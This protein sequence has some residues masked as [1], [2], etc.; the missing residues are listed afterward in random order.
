M[1]NFYM[2]QSG[3]RPALVLLP[4][5]PKCWSYR[6]A[7]FRLFTQFIILFIC[8]GMHAGVLQLWHSGN[9]EGREELARISPL[10]PL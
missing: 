2:V 7:A 1:N 8:V 5:P 9:V 4:Q 10:L 3:F 6:N